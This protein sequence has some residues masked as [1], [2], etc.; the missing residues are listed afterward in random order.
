[1]LLFRPGLVISV[2]NRGEKLIIMPRRS[3]KSRLIEAGPEG[4]GAESLA[5]VRRRARWQKRL[6]AR[7][8]SLLCL[9]QTGE[10]RRRA[11][12][13]GLIAR[14]IRNA[15]Q[16]AARMHRRQQRSAPSSSAKAETI[17][18]IETAAQRFEIIR[19]EEP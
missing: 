17:S 10:K 19:A 11:C 9:K 18:E 6:G 2:A 5:Y 15:D 8:P 16:P 13:G 14:D 4:V 7:P 1:M 3:A 12:G